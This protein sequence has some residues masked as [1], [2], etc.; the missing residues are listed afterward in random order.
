MPAKPQDKPL[1]IDIKNGQLSITIGLGFLA[2]MFVEYSE[3]CGEEWEISD[4][5]KFGSELKEKLEEERVEDGATSVHMLLDHVLA[6]MLL[7]G[8]ESVVYKGKVDEGE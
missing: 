1:K 3:E 5:R 6:K 8:A 2:Q 4:L 7:N